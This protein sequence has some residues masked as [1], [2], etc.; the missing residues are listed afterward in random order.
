MEDKH[1]CHVTLFD[2]RKTPLKFEKLG[3][4]L[5]AITVHH[6]HHGVRSCLAPCRHISNVLLQGINLLLFLLS[7]IGFEQRLLNDALP[8]NT[9][10]RLTGKKKEEIAVV[11]A[12]LR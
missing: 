7:E 1:S 12:N 3:H 2:F 9:F 10:R 4:N 11:S 5:S 8:S 6:C